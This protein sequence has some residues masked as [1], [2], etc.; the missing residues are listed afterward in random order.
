MECK[1]KS[2]IEGYIVNRKCIMKYIWIEETL[3]ITVLLSVPKCPFYFSELL[4][5]SLV[6]K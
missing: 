6:P 5:L 3:N 2:L 1:Q 4:N